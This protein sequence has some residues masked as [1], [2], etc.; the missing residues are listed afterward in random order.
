MHRTLLAVVV[1]VAASSFAQSD[2]WNTFP[3]AQPAPTQPA[4]KPQ[5]RPEQPK[6][7]P[8]PKQTTAPAEAK[9]LP[10][11]LAA[12]LDAGVP[13]SD[14]GVDGGVDAARIV[15]QTE[16]YLPGTEP[17]SPSTW[18]LPWDATE[19]ARV[20]V[21]H[22]GIGTV[23]V[24]SARLGKAGVVRVSLLGEYHNIQ[25]FPVRSAQNIRSGVTFAASFQPF[26]WGE[27]F[28]AYGAAANSNN[29]TSPNLIQAL[30]D[31]QLGIKLS[32]EWARGFHAGV[33]LRLITFSGVGNQGLDR[34]AVGF[35]PTLLLTYDFRTLS[36]YIPLVLTGGFGATIDSSSGLVS[37]Q[38]LNAAEEYALNVNRYHRLNV[39][40]AAEI[41]FPVVT[42][43]VEYQ[44]SPVLGAPN[45]ELTGPDGR[46]VSAGAAMAH[47]LGLGLKLTPLKDL[48]V[49]SGFNLGLAR[50]VGLGVP[51]T[52]P[53]NF[54]VGAGFAIDPFQKGETKIVETIRERRVDVARAPPPQR[55]EGVVTDEETKQPLSNVIIAV[56]GNKPTA[57]DA[58][59]AYE[60]LPV[61][62]KSVKLSIAKEGYAPYEQSIAV[63]PAQP[64]R[65][66]VA[67]KPDVK[68]AKF[69]VSTTANKKP[70]KANVTFR[71]TA[72]ARAETPDGNAPAEV[73]LPAGTYTITATAP[74]HLAQTRDVQVQ[75]GGKLVVTFE[76]QPSPRKVLVVFKGDK[77]EI[78][79]QVHFASGKAQIL[80]DSFGLLQQVVDAIITNNVK[81][82]RV[83]GH[84]DNRGKKE[85]NQTLSEDR[86]RAVKDYLVAQGIDASRLESAGYGDSKPIAPNL[87]ARGRE[88]N[89]RVEFIVLEK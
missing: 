6:P 11:R 71:G 68:K 26:D 79:Q 84:T 58:T 22:V 65:V 74:G 87:T 70:I 12:A 7:Q 25:D 37:N 39:M 2:E 19:N 77:I 54:F 32:R 3:P 56:A 76:L 85:T 57:T 75:A 18:G 8:P 78:L 82:V 34:F 52:P 43:F 40:A 49:T 23:Y 36:H 28:V 13:S 29:R 33:D 50:S 73:E 64:T 27:I 42:P 69:E 83:E 81:R 66:D 48:T 41:P 20:A 5:P 72:E 62:G 45:G 59:G 89:R 35:K 10:P 51:A 46:F 47:T 21:G 9:P 15:S 67:L 24:P 80:P 17:H 60:S 14:G 86:A 38:R 31:L 53:W 30:G 88:L 63:D 4:P 1:V 44:V 16:R 55:L 61:T